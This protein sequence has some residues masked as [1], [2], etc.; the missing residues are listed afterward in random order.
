MADL[1]DISGFITEAAVPDLAWLEVKP[2][3]YRAQDRLPQQNLDTIPDLEAA[4]SHEGKD[5]SAYYVQNSGVLENLAALS[6][7]HRTA[8]ASPDFTRVARVVFL[9]SQ[10]DAQRFLSTMAQKFDVDTLRANRQVMANLL[11][12]KGLFGSYY[13]EAQDFPSC[14]A[15]GKAPLSFVQKHAATSRFLVAKT[16]CQDCVHR[17]EAPGVAPRCAVFQRQLVWEV[18]YQDAIAAGIEAQQQAKGH[19]ATAGA[20]PR[21]RIKNAYLAPLKKDASLAP[22]FKENTARNLAPVVPVPEVKLPPDLLWA[23]KKAEDYIAWAHQVGK[24]TAQEVSDAGAVVRMA[25]SREDIAGVLRQVEAL[26]APAARVYDAPLPPPPPPPVTPEDISRGLIAAQA[27]TKKKAEKVASEISQREAAPVIALLQR[28]MIKGRKPHELAQA[29]RLA[30]GQDLLTKTRE[31]WE[32]LAREAGVFGIVYLPQTTFTDC[33]QGS[34]FVSKHNPSLKMVVAGSKCQGC[35][36]NRGGSCAEY[37]KPLVAS[38]TAAYRED[39]VKVAFQEKVSLGHMRPQQWQ[40]YASMGPKEAL[41]ALHREAA[42]TNAIP[43]PRSGDIYTVFAGHGKEHST[44]DLTRRS[45]VRLA[46]QQLNQGLYGEDLLQALRLAFDERDLKATL[47][48]LRNVLAEQG[49]QGVYYVDPAVYEDYGQGCEEASRLHLA[50]GIKYAKVGPKCATCIHQQ[51]KGQCSKLKKAL[52]VEPPYHD[53]AAQQKAILSSGAATEVDYASLVNNGA[54]ML[55]DYELVEGG[56]DV[57]LDPETAPEEYKVEW[58]GGI[59]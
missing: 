54:K 16:S 52:V 10:G 7:S 19:V 43:V 40:R 23:R 46:S 13:I 39:V 5:P 15:N 18:P 53:K 49:L 35:V 26:E 33:R 57:D 56:L 2:E 50:R 37:N 38:S 55:S 30:F 31:A 36:F 28:E 11:S 6:E 27:L 12:E 14:Q 45:I 8:S 48:E 44:S 47:P 41:Q 34:E 22:T 21:E 32:P 4:W 42:P 59:L 3:E 58:G 29:M 17:Q 9:A 24:I 51:V 1:G 25:S 20:D